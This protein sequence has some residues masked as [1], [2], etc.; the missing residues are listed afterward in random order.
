MVAFPSA[1]EALDCAIEMQQLL[2]RHGED[3]QPDQR[4]QLRV[5]LHAGEP[6]RQRGDYFGTPVVVAQRLC[7]RA[8]GGQILTSDLVRG[9][10]GSRG[11]HDFRGVGP[12]QLKGIAEHVEALSGAGEDI[13]NQEFRQ[14]RAPQGS[15]HLAEVF[16][17]S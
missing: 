7:D 10:V 13:S 8:A 16:R 2:H 15:N 1:L 4:L 12:L 6:I 5:G 9:L 14:Q 11:G 17:C 3:Q